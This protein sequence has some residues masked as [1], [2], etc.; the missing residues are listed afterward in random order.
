MN[1][2]AA[3]L[4]GPELA[5]VLMLAIAGMLIARNEPVTEAGNDQ[6]LN[7]GWFLL[8]TAVLLSFVPL[9]WAPGSPWWWLFRII[10]VGFFSTI[11]LSSLIC[12]G[13]DYRDSRNSG[14]GTAF[15]L[16]IGVG[17]VFLFGG[18][19]VAAIFFLTKWNF[20]PVLKWSLIVIGSLTA[21]FSL[22]FWLAS[23]GKSAAS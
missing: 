21:F 2:T 16:Y 9:F 20:L 11:L 19:F 4:L 10:F 12:G 3:Y 15:I 13:V 22:I 17:Y 18:A 5:W 23:F 1:R 8:I 14:V 6:L 7:S